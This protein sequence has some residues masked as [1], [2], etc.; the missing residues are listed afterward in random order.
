[1]N[2]E[3][4]REREGER[5]GEHPISIGISILQAAI[6]RLQDVACGM[7][8]GCHSMAASWHCSPSLGDKLTFTHAAKFKW[9]GVEMGWGRVLRLVLHGVDCLPHKPGYLPK[10]SYTQTHT[11]RLCHNST[12]CGHAQDVITYKCTWVCVRVCV[13]VNVCVRY[14]DYRNMLCATCCNANRR[15]SATRLVLVA[16]QLN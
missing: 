8:R 11:Q 4:E 12:F 14:S 2:S 6:R 15:Q 7:K 1:M 13:S 3:R 16:P 5:E 9:N 10:Y